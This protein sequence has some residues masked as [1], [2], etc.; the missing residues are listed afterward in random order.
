MNDLSTMNKIMEY[1]A[2]GKPIVQ[3]D[4]R[5]GRASRAMNCRPASSPAL[6]RRWTG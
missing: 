4:V 6:A 2:M 1:M 3:F 5:E